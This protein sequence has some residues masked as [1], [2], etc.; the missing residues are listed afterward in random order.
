MRNANSRLLPTWGMQSRLLPPSM[1]T[2]PKPLLT[3]EVK[4][5]PLSSLEVQRGIFKQPT[6][7]CPIDS[8]PSTCKKDNEA[9]TM[10]FKQGWL[11]LPNQPTITVTPSSDQRLGK[12]TISLQGPLPTA[13][14]QHP[15]SCRQRCSRLM[16]FC[17][18][19]HPLLSFC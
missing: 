9:I 17:Q 14:Q 8:V 11:F 6:K 16:S 4:T 5:K 12:L 2:Q 13:N 15:T 7:A 19:M 18:M 1:K 10:S 3:W